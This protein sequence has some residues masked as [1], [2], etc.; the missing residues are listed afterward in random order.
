VC[1]TANSEIQLFQYRERIIIFSP[2]D[3]Y[4][5]DMDKAILRS[6]MQLMVFFY[7]YPSFFIL[8]F[9]SPCSS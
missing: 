7:F 1:L 8:L 6:I 5:E 2:S 3:N 9:N 4:A